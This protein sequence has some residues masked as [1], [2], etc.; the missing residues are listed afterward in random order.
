L[1]S[2]FMME[3]SWQNTISGCEIKTYS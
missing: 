3:G 1:L 2:T